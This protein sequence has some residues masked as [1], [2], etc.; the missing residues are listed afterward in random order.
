MPEENSITLG[1]GGPTGPTG[2]SGGSP[3]IP[4]GGDDPEINVD[5]LFAE[6]K[7]Q[8]K[9]TR[10]IW[11]IVYLGF[12]VLVVTCLGVAIAFLSLVIQFFGYTYTAAPK[13][14]STTTTPVRE[15][16]PPFKSQLINL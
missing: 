8:A 12:I 2:P 3:Q 11:N 14:T 9:K 16:Q 6:I 10:E 15:I 5:R 13:N 7:A 1:T 4:E